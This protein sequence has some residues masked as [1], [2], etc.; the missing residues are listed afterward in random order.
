MNRLPKSFKTS[1][2]WMSFSPPEEAR[3]LRVGLQ[4]YLLSSSPN[5]TTTMC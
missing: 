2:V 5:A 3:L 4:I 1:E